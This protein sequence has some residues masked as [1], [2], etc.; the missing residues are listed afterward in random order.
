[1]G[2]ARLTLQTD[3]V[4]EPE[5]QKRPAD[6]REGA[7]GVA[8]IEIP[9]D[10]DCGPYAHIAGRI[11]LHDDFFDTELTAKAGEPLALKLRNTDV[12]PHNLVLVQPGKTREIGEASF[13]MLNDPKAGDKSYVPDSPDV[14]GFIPVI[15]PESEHTLHFRAP[16]KPGDY[17]YLCTF[18]GHWQVMRGILKVR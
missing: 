14:I 2:V 9:I 12:M 1:M 10:A 16:E 18:P 15:D 6:A 3:P 4:G 17:P 13:K 5:T 8:E 7:V 11:L